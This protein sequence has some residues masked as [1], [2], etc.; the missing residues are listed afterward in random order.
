MITPP[1]GAGAGG[2]SDLNVATEKRDRLWDVLTNVNNIR[3]PNS[4]QIKEADQKKLTFFNRNIINDLACVQ[5]KSGLL[6]VFSPDGGAKPMLDMDPG[7]AIGIRK[8]WDLNKPAELTSTDH[9]NALLTGSA[10][11]RMSMGNAGATLTTPNDNSRAMME[12][13]AQLSGLTVANPKYAK[14]EDLE[15]ALKAIDPNLS[16]NMTAQW[17]AMKD[18]Y[19]PES[20]SPTPIKQPAPAA[21]ATPAAKTATEVKAADL[22]ALLKSGKPVLLEVTAENDDKSKQQVPEIDK[23][24]A[25]A[26]GKAQVVKMDINELHNYLDTLP[27]DDPQRTAIEAGLK[28]A[29]AVAVFDDKGQMKGIQTGFQTADKVQAFFNSNVTKDEAIPNPTPAAAQPA[30]PA[31]TGGAAP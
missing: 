22:P 5:N 16:K 27:K 26:G 14:P 11:A 6:T 25:Q 7:G 15:A 18:K 24:A 19:E 17:Q 31:P 4:P 30:K 29:P 1:A 10:L 3:N 2:V 13:A 20:F 28:G 12:K 8:N 21:A 23:L 9:I